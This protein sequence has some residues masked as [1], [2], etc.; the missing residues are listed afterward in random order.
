M[1]VGRMALFAALVVA[2]SMVAAVPVIADDPP[3]TAPG[4]ETTEARAAEAAPPPPWVTAIRIQSTLEC[5]AGWTRHRG[6]LRDAPSLSS[7]YVRRIEV[8]VDGPLT[9]WADA[10]FVMN[11]EGIGNL[12]DPGDGKL[13]LDEGHIGL[14]RDD[15]PVYITIGKRTQPFGSFENH[16]ITDPLIQDAYEVNQPGATVG[17]TGPLGLDVSATAY[18]GQAQMDHLFASGLFDS[19]VVRR[20]RRDANRVESVIGSLVLI[21][22]PDRLTCFASCLSEPGAGR[23]NATVNAGATLTSRANRFMLDAEYMQALAREDYAG[24]GRAFRERALST[25]VAYIVDAHGRHGR[26]SGSFRGRRSHIRAFPVEIAAR[27]ERF[28]DGGLTRQLGAWSV[29]DRVSLG[30]RQTLSRVDAGV[31]YALIEYRRSTWRVP[32]ASAVSL[33]KRNDEV[34]AR[35]GM[36]F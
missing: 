34:Y 27:Y 12:L 18:A 13:G 16:I 10:F 31:L 25:T 1:P 9:D 21:P 36:G 15:I 3:R 30:L 35:I 29:R 28:D 33:E 26:G 4:A 11:S 7:L 22:L 14:Q 17:Y 19:T 5:E 8:A 20:V 2:L 32:G 24:Q 23:R 6:R